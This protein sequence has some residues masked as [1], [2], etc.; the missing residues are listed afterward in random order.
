M[1]RLVKWVGLPEGVVPDVAVFWSNYAPIAKADEAPRERKRTLPV[2]DA[3]WAQRFPAPANAAS[4]GAVKLSKFVPS[5]IYEN[6]F[7]RDAATVDPTGLLGD[8]FYRKTLDERASQGY[9]EEACA[10]H[11]SEHLRND[12]SKRPQPRVSDLP[13]GVFGRYV[14][15]PTQKFDDV[16]VARFSNVSLP[17]LLESAASF[18]AEKGLTLVVKIHPHLKSAAPQE[19]ALQTKFVGALRSRCNAA[20][21]LSEASVNL[22]TRNALF[23]ATVNGG[24]LMDNCYTG[25]PVLTVAKSL[26]GFAQAVVHDADTPSDNVRAMEWHLNNLVF[27]LPR[28]RPPISLARV[29]SS[30]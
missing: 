9:D 12:S 8:S 19:W 4:F 29:D 26:F 7:T 6:G 22:L 30:S 16:S 23:T 24:T 15:I 28:S 27:S 20:V 17:Q 13:A 11:V 3:I 10:A 25:T 21:V 1:A 18:C 14:F 5:V 2:I